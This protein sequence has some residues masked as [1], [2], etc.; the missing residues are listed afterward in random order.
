VVVVVSDVVPEPLLYV[1]LWE[2]PSDP[3]GPTD[4]FVVVVLRVSGGGGTTTVGAGTVGAGTVG[5]GGAV[6]I[7]CDVCAM[8]TLVSKPSAAEPANTTRV[9]SVLRANAL[10]RQLPRIPSEV[11]GDEDIWMQAW[12]P[13]MEVKT[14]RNRDE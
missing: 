10:P 7:V 13:H 12:K 8:A 2:E 14:H 3:S 5:A 4:F 1:V 9:M 11:T 6:I